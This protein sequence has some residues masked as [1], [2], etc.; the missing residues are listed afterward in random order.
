MSDTFTP[1]PLY[2]DVLR[3]EPGADIVTV[4]LPGILARAEQQF[5]PILPYLPG[6]VVGFTPTGPTYDHY[7]FVGTVALAIS[8]MI[9]AG[10]VVN[11]VGASMGGMQ[12][13][14]VVA[15][16]R[17]YDIDLTSFGKIV[18]IDAPNGAE[19]MGEIPPSAVSI[20]A[21]N[22]VRRVMYTRFGDWVLDRMVKPPKSDEVDIPQADVRSWIAGRPVD[23]SDWTMFVQRT[24]RQQLKGWP[25]SLWIGQVQWMLA[26]GRGPLTRTA[27]VLRALDVTYVACS[28]PGNVTVKQP[29]AAN[30][31]ESVAGVKV[32]TV[33]A[34]HCGFWQQ[35][36]PFAAALE[37]IFG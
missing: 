19:T 32:V 29:N 1:L 10:K 23:E 27:N 11:L 18:L 37:K 33:D 3:R 17:M 12:I 20:M 6:H 24:A 26:A 14:F 2:S 7:E 30:W 9:D 31:W 15:R 5:H 25:G 35:P 21:S 34:V 22:T 13:P 16:L 8:R 28:H 36:E 4:V